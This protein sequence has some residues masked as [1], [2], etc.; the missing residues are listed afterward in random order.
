MKH[1]RLVFLALVTSVFTTFAQEVLL[2]DNFATGINDWFAGLGQIRVVDQTLSVYGSFGRMD[3]NNVVEASA[4]GTHP[5]PTTTRLLDQQTLE[6]RVDLIGIGKKGTWAGI[7][8]VWTDPVRAYAMFLDSGNIGLAKVRF[9]GGPGAWFFHEQPALKSKNLTLVL[10][11]TRIGS[12]LRISTRVLDK[13]NSSAVLFDRTVTDTPQVDP[14]LPNRA[15]L[16]E[17][18]GPDWIGTPFPLLSA[19]NGVALIT[20]WT[21]SVIGSQGITEVVFDNVEVRRYKAP[22]LTIEPAVLV[23][24]PAVPGNW[25]LE[26]SA[27]V[28]G[29]YAPLPQVPALVADRLQVAVATSDQTRFFRLRF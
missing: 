19:P 7:D 22:E 10:S 23:S 29:P 26:S 11:L 6:L 28:N 25:I 1:L 12:D 18:S 24:W 8:F 17:V 4:N 5:I 2:I 15:V 14:A 16:G 13:E 21:D 27:N 9:D 20:R 3:T